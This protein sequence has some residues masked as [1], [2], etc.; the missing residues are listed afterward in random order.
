MLQLP[1]Y[2]LGAVDVDKFVSRDLCKGLVKSGMDACNSILLL[3]KYVLAIS[4]GHDPVNISISLNRRHHNQISLMTQSLKS[5]NFMT[6]KTENHFDLK[7]TN[8]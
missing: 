1:L 4:V 8:I 2:S 7:T 3:K 6:F 5:K